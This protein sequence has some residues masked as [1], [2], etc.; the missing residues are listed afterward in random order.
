MPFKKN[1]S[2]CRS[3]KPQGGKSMRYLKRLITGIYIYLGAF[4]A[5]CLLV[6]YLT[7][8]APQSLIVAVNAAVGLESLVAA[9]LKMTETKM[10]ALT[11][12]TSTEQVNNIS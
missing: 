5:S 2:R 1:G 10:E 8:D 3:G 9:L 7:G 12:K 4:N 11:A 6:W